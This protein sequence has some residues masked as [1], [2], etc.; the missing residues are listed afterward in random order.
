VFDRD[1]L[2]TTASR[3][4]FAPLKSKTFYKIDVWKYDIQN[5]MKIHLEV[6]ER[7][8]VLISRLCDDPIFFFFPTPNPLTSG[9]TTSFSRLASGLQA[10]PRIVFVPM[11]LCCIGGVCIPETAVLPILLI[12]IKWLYEKLTSWEV[13]PVSVQKWFEAITGK[14]TTVNQVTPCDG[15][16][17]KAIAP[18]KS[19]KNIYVI[20]STDEFKSLV[21]RNETISIK[22]TAT[23]CKPCSAIK[24]L[25]RELATDY[26]AHFLEIDVDEFDDIAAKYN[27][28]MLPCFIIL[29]GLQS[30]P[31]ILTGSSEKSIRLFY[32]RHL[33]K[34]V[35]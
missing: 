23:W 17:P 16:A 22:F 28:K 35:E 30:N 12:M 18:L 4:S 7:E 9:H 5:S 20:E 2:H 19:S 10:I 25:Y 26:A 14:E 1:L 32:D 24:E 11:A 31:E 15:G 21:Q 8:E 6:M 3:I 34:R 27:V 29:H 13:L 33:H